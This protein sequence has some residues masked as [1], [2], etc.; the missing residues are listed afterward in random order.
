M[1]RHLDASGPLFLQFNDLAV[2]SYHR[3]GWNFKPMR[4]S[5]GDVSINAIVTGFP[6]NSCAPD[7]TD[8]TSFRLFV[9]HRMTVGLHLL[10]NEKGCIDCPHHYEDLHCHSLG[11]LGFTIQPSHRHDICCDYS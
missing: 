11:N 5:A 8:E 2:D 1:K 6:A 10:K 9:P 4:N 3:G 7:F